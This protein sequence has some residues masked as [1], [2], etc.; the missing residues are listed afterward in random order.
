MSLFEKSIKARIM[1]YIL[2]WAM[3]PTVRKIYLVCGLKKAKAK[4]TWMQIFDELK[5]RGIED[6]LFISMDGVSGL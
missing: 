3:T 6:V 1:L 5:T 4:H 2:S